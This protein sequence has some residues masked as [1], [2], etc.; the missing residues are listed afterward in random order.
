MPRTLR[1]LIVS[2]DRLIARLRELALTSPSALATGIEKEARAELF[3]AFA[4]DV[5]TALREAEEHAQ[6]L[7]AKLGEGP[8]PFTFATVSG[9]AR[10][11]AVTEHRDRWHSRLREGAA[12]SHELSRLLAAAA[13]LVDVLAAAEAAA[14]PA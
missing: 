9:R 11:A 14:G 7:L 5:A 3:E 2:L 8:G 12:T 13:P 6:A 4:D 10:R 1:K